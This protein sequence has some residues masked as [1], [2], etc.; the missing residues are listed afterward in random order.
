[1]KMESLTVY[2]VFFY[3][4]EIVQSMT[5]PPPIRSGPYC[6][7]ENNIKIILIKGDLAKQEVNI[8]FL[9]FNRYVKIQWLTFTNHPYTPL[10]K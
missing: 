5:I 6:C 4:T 7:A 9:G 8:N 1:M 3:L 2:N 10:I